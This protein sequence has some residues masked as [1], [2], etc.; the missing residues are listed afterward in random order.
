MLRNH[1]GGQTPL[2]PIELFFEL[3][4]VFAITLLSHYLLAKLTWLVR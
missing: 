3:I 1:G 4:F 2:K